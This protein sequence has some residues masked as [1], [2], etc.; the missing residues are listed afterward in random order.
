MHA[1]RGRF[2]GEK[3]IVPEAASGFLPGEVIVVFADAGEEAADR[4]IWAKAQ[5]AAFA[6]VWMNDADALYDNL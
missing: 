6:A 2:D 5:E 1:I 4:A 3:V